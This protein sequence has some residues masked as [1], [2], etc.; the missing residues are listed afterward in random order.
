M[1]AMSERELRNAFCLAID[2]VRTEPVLIPK[3]RRG[4]VMVI[5]VE[6]L[7]DAI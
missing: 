5:F 7:S 6:R 2:T 4:V 3:H 1:K